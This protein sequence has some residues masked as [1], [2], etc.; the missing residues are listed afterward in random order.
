MF[1][2]ARLVLCDP[3]AALPRQVLKLELRVFLA[4]RRTAVACDWAALAGGP[5]CATFRTLLGDPVAVLFPVVVV[6]EFRVVLA[7]SRGW[8]WCGSRSWT[9]AACYRAVL[10][11]GAELSA[12]DSRLLCNPGTVLSVSEREFQVVRAGTAVA[13]DWAA[14]AGGPQ[15]ATFRTLLGDPVTVLPPLVLVQEVSFVLASQHSLGRRKAQ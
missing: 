5:Q 10:S 3:G 11:G 1:A 2:S 15:C 12:S 9:G 6:L 14:L 4:G 8:S 13:C 7:G